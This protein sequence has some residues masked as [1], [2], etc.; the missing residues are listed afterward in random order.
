MKILVTFALE[1]EFAAWRAMRD[2]RPKKMGNAEA[3]DAKIDA[4]DVQVVVTGVGARIAGLRARDVLKSNGDSVEFVISSGSAG[5]ARRPYAIGQVLAARA[6]KLHASGAG[7]ATTIECSSALVSFAESCGATIVD[8]FYT[9]ER[10]ISTREEKQHIG[11]FADAIE[12]ESFGIL[13]EAAESGVP[14]VAIRA[15]SDLADENLPLDMNE[16]FS[17]EGKVSIPRV[18]GQVARHPGALSGLIKLG[19]Q[20]KT[21][22]EALA[23]FLDRYVAIVAERN[24]VLN[25]RGAA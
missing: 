1:S 7:N 2:F 23:R 24:E 9:S 17:D 18:L 16:V 15:V 20:S 6:V 14:A 10:A 3:Y 19:Q 5:A 12:M 13:T 4:A 11:E 25:A 8:R 21:A 22:A